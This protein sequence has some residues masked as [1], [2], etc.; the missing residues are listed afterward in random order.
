MKSVADG[1]T[2]SQPRRSGPAAGGP[3]GP[4]RV[5]T[6]DG[7][8]GP[9]SICAASAASA[10]SAACPPRPLVLA[11]NS[12]YR[13]TQRAGRSASD[14]GWIV[15]VMVISL[16]NLNHFCSLGYVPCA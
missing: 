7:P 9:A 4:P 6:I 2:G 14:H 16:W 10:A 15:G 11:S 5:R 13:A 3:P 1:I 12:N 8:A